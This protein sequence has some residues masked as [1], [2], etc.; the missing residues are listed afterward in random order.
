MRRTVLSLFILLP[1]VGIALGGCESSK[2]AGDGSAPKV[3]M[4]TQKP[5]KVELA[6]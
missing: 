2:K 5:K 3:L 1:L 4:P 6:Q